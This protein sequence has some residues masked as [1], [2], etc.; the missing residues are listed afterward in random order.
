MTSNTIILQTII[1][2]CFREF[3][4]ALDL[5]DIADS[6][7]KARP[8]V[9]PEKFKGTVQKESVEK[10]WLCSIYISKFWGVV[11]LL[12]DIIFYGLITSLCV[13]STDSLLTHPS[14]HNIYSCI[15]STIWPFGNFLGRLVFAQA[16]IPSSMGLICEIRARIFILLRGPG[17]D[18][19]ELIPLAYVA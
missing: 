10:Y 3:Q 7:A 14:L 18:S 1:F 2:S 8:R 9:N 13:P 11:G 6:L 17:I 15:D 16:S 4:K 12:N 19:K 5:L